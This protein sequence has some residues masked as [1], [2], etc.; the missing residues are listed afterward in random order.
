MTRDELL[1]MISDT[2]TWGQAWQ[3][4]PHEPLLP[5]VALGRVLT[6]GQ[7]VIARRILNLGCAIYWRAPASKA[8]LTLLT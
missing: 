5:L 3:P 2:S 7:R 1:E 4:A 8:Q 6:E